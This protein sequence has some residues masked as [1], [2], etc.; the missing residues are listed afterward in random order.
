[1]LVVGDQAPHEDAVVSKEFWGDEGVLGSED[2]GQSVSCQGKALFKT[3]RAI[4]HSEFDS[5]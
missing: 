4:E 1:M 2:D 5:C 3:G